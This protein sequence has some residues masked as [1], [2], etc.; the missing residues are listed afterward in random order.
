M[1]TI[2]IQDAI[3]DCLASLGACV[4]FFGLHGSICSRGLFC[5]SLDC[6]L[7]RV[8]GSKELSI[9]LLKTQIRKC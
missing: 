9:K 5:G 2:Y 6:S 4:S 7:S 8:L 3:F 1:L